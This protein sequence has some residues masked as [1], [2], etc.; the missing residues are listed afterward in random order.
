MPPPSPTP[1]F[2]PAL[3]AA[4]NPPKPFTH[5]GQDQ[6]N[7]NSVYVVFPEKHIVTRI[8]EGA[9]GLLGLVYM[10]WTV[11]RVIAHKGGKENNLDVELQAMSV[12][13]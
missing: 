13:I 5:R 6:R 10:G 2:A 4:A 3:P 12:H 7:Y 8:I 9:V 11:W 1:D